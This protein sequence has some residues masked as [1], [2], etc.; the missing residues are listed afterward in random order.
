MPIDEQDATRQA[1]APA[2]TTYPSVEN[3]WD[4][5]AADY[6]DIY[7]RFA[8]T[9]NDGALDAAIRQVVG[10][11]EGKVVLD[12]GAGTGQ[13]AFGFANEA[14]K[15]LGLE[16][17]PALLDFDQQVIAEK[18][19]TNILPFHGLPNDLPIND[20]VL[21]VVLAVTVAPWDPDPIMRQG[22]RK[23][24][25]E[26]ALRVLKPGGVFVVV[27]VPEGAYGGELAPIIFDDPAKLPNNSDWDAQLVEDFGFQFT[28]IESVSDYGTVENAVATYGF[29]FG[30][31]AI[32]H[33]LEHQKHTI[34]WR[35]RVLWKEKAAAQPAETQPEEA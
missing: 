30:Q 21:D 23:R 19:Y 6:P 17:D 22:L 25:V 29:I 15:I 31:R 28:E 5:L 8:N 32:R 7:E 27:T 35:Y 26:E 10:A 9:P 11:F 24:M 3:D 2:A 13:Y 20:D 1:E 33:L 16:V 12:M 4:K 34:T 14:Y 18:G